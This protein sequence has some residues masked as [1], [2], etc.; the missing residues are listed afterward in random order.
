MR[1]IVRILVG[2][3]TIPIALIIIHIERAL[4]ARRD[5]DHGQE[6]DPADARRSR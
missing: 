3:A 4:R 2:A 1:R 6:N 5:G